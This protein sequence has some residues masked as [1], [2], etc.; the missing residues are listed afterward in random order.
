MEG[1]P[2]PD[3]QRARRAAKVHYTALIVAYI[4]FT[5]MLILQRCWFYKGKPLDFL[6]SSS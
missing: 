5:K 3:L 6:K 4:F 1:I 2:V